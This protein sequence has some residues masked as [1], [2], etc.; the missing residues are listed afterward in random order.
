MAVVEGYT[1]LLPTH[2]PFEALEDVKIALLLRD[3]GI[4][5]LSLHD[6][7]DFKLSGEKTKGVDVCPRSRAA[8]CDPLFNPN[9]HIEER[10][11]T[12]CKF[13]HV[14]YLVAF[15]NLVK[16]GTAIKGRELLRVYEQ[17]ARVFS[18]LT[19]VQNYPKAVVLEGEIAKKYEEVKEKP[20]IKYEDVI[21]RD[22]NRL[23]RLREKLNQLTERIASDFGFSNYSEAKILYYPCLEREELLL[24]RGKEF[25]GK[26]VGYIGPFLILE[27]RNHVESIVDL[28]EIEGMNIG[29]YIV[30]S[31]FGEK[32]EIY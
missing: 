4:V 23:Q 28:R 19:V 31:L 16:V 21:V 18:V 2:S 15:R 1:Y 32:T 14:V 3:V 26:I 5:P 24:I 25:R 22:D 7:V 30:D 13:P 10:R 29:G 11:Q 27:D 20:R 12:I 6:F 17:G 9:C 8:T